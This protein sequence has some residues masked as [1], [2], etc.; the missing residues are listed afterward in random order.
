[1]N[2]SNTLVIPNGLNDTLFGI[3]AIITAVVL[4]YTFGFSELMKK[5]I[6]KLKDAKRVAVD[7]LML[8][9]IR[10]E[11]M[12]EEDEY[13][14]AQYDGTEGINPNYFGATLIAE[15]KQLAKLGSIFQS[16]GFKRDSEGTFYETTVGAIEES[17]ILHNQKIVEHLYSKEGK[18]QFKSL[19]N[20]PAQMIRYFSNQLSKENIV[21][22]IDIDDIEKD[23]SFVE[24]D[25]DNI[26][27]AILFFKENNNT[28]QNCLLYRKTQSKSASDLVSLF[29]ASADAASNSY[30]PD[31]KLS[32][33]AEDETVTKIILK[34]FP[35]AKVS[36]KMVTYML[37]FNAA[38]Y[39]EFSM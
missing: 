24:M 6:S 36:Q 14:E 31:V 9:K 20:I 37:P 15:P 17:D 5:K 7:G 12:Q 27:A 33:F 4:I 26:V 18:Q 35:D 23:I 22:G 2:Y 30:S 3:L 39:K 13:D 28:L 32:F 38:L 1:M 10:E 29:T 16:C 8:Q 19:K 25:G 34:V 21:P 11:N